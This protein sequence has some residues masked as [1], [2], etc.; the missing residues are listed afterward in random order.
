MST[1]GGGV[2]GVGHGQMEAPSI[3]IVSLRMRC[4]SQRRLWQA[5][6]VEQ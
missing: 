5:E 2:E 6:S 1:A 3:F 4:Y